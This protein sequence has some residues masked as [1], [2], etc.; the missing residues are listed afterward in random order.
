MSDYRHTLLKDYDALRLEYDA[1]LSV[2]SALLRAPLF[3][4]LC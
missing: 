2:L 4:F 1:M 3:V